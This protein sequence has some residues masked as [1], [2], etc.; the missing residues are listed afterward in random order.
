MNYNVAGNLSSFWAHILDR[1]RM[2]TLL[3]PDPI[4][5]PFIKLVRSMALQYR[6]GTKKSKSLHIRTKG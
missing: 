5:C 6:H 2:I 1:K 4:V 3:I